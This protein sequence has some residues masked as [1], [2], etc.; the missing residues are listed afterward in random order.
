MAAPYQV[1]GMAMESSELITPSAHQEKMN[2]MMPRRSKAPAL[3]DGS[4]R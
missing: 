1:G 2:A 3:D 4:T